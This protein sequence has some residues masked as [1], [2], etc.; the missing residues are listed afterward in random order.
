MKELRRVIDVMCPECH[1]QPG[2][3]CMA[4]PIWSSRPKPS[5]PAHDE[6][7]AAFNDQLAARRQQE[8]R[9]LGQ[10]ELPHAEG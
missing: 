4:A 9:E 6:R 5:V 7:R 8:A 2:H 3:L 10:L 1:A